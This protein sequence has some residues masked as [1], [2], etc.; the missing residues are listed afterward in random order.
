MDKKAHKKASDPPQALQ[1][2]QTAEAKV[3]V[4][5]PETVCTASLRK[6]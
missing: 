3:Q 5:N 2:A 4:R 1:A 6:R